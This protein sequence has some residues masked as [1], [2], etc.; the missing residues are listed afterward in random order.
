M[1]SHWDM[2]EMRFRV[3]VPNKHVTAVAADIRERFDRYVVRRGPC[4]YCNDDATALLLVIRA[5]GAPL[6]ERPTD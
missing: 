2:P 6:E 4:F 3:T 1:S 5:H